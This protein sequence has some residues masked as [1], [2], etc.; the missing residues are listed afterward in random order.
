MAA[1]PTIYKFKI[2]LSD[3]DNN[4][5]DNLNLTVALH[6]SETIERMMVRVLAFCFNAR[7]NI[8]FTKGLYEPEE[9]DLWAQTLDG[10]I[11]LWIDVG[12]PTADRIKKASRKAKQTW[13]Y[14]FNTKSDAWW[15]QN[16]R[17]V[18]KHGVNVR[19]LAYSQMQDLAV[20]AERTCDASL[21]LSEDSALF[22]T[23]A[24]AC[25][26]NWTDLTS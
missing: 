20:L 12:E 24:G 10:L 19:Q 14:T 5:Y 4:Y 25:E 18:I 23:G 22:A 17:S 21:T 6:P 13:V 2:A 7:Q 1:K 3:L 11:D 26:I 16:Q 15:Q 9:P 8:T